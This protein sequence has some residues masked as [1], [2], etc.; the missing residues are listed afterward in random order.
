MLWGVESRQVRVGEGCGRL[1]VCVCVWRKESTL[2]GAKGRARDPR[3]LEH[4]SCRILAS[5]LTHPTSPAL[6]LAG[7]L[8]EAGMNSKVTSAAGWSLEWSVGALGWWGK[9]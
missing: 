4:P 2:D 6:P 9:G 3:G 1:C 7:P 8:T 5:V